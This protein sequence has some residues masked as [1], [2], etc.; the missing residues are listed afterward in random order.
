MHHLSDKEKILTNEQNITYYDRIANSYDQLMEQDDSN[1]LI[2]QKVKAKFLSYV[3]AGQVLDFG[4]GTGIDLEWLSANN[5]KIFFCEPSVSMREKAMQYNNNILHYNDIVFLDTAQTDFTGW[6][7][8]P[9]F[10]EQVDA[11][12]SNFA[13]INNIQ[14]IE[15]LFK[16]LAL[17]IKPGGHFMIVFLDLSFKKKLGLNRRS[18]I[19]S[20]IF[21]TTFIMYVWH[22]EHKQT[23]FVH[24]E[25]KIKKASAP[26]FR[27]CSAEVLGGFGFKLMH[28]RR[29]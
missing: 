22:H 6:G 21:R 10:S 9:P 12:L 15:L 25:K 2:R 4:G 3:Q 23:V 20:F 8:V 1:K 13:V 27:Y 14:D 29:K 19:Q 26:Y 11:I 16:H 5:Y 24:P 28:L 7:K 18:A 17:V